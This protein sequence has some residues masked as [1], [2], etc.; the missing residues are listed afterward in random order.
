MGFFDNNQAGVYK[1]LTGLQIRL[2][3]E[4]F[5]ERGTLHAPLISSLILGVAGIPEVTITEITE[6]GIT[7]TIIEAVNPGVTEAAEAA[8]SGIPE[9]GVIEALEVTVQ[10]SDGVI[11]TPVA[12]HLGES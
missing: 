10:P 9:A 4:S 3:Y 8:V 6:A 1:N 12:T 7:D 11:G 5:L 2:M